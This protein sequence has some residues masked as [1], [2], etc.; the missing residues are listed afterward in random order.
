MEQLNGILFIDIETVPLEPEFALLSE[1]MQAEWVRKAKF[2]KSVTQ[3]ANPAAIFDERAGIFSEFAKV[4]CISF[5]SIHKMEDKWVMRLKS[6]AFDDEKKL[7]NDF[8][9]MVG[10]FNRHFNDVRFCGHN[11]KEFD[12]PFICRRMVINGITLPACMQISG[13]KPWEI[14]H[15]DTMELWKFGDHKHFTSLSLLAQV[16]GIPSPKGDID[17]SMVA[18][19]YWKDK[20]LA[21]ISTYCQ[22]DVLT[23]AK[24]YLRLKGINIELEPVFV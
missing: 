16:L 6:I 15:L 9:E 13:K 20:D 23:T 17:G 14:T 1:G 10:K 12:I 8:C 18:D 5:G 24:V 7:L 19:V 2:V 4:V 22:K 11:I 3:D 21:R